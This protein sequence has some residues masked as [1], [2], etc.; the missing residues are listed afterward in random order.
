MKFASPRSTPARRCPSELTFTTRGRTASPALARNSGNSSAVSRKCARW[1]V[2]NWSSKPSAVRVSGGNITPALLTS[3]SRRS[4]SARK[5]AA[6]VRTDARS[7]R[8]TT[9]TSAR[10]PDTSSRNRASAASSLARSRAA[11]VTRA[12]CAASAR[13]VSKPIPPDAPVMRNSVPARSR[14]AST[15]SAVVVASNVTTSYL[16]HHASRAR[17]TPARAPDVLTGRCGQVAGVATALKV[18]PGPG[19]SWFKTGVSSE[20]VLNCGI[21]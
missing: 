2:P 6:N 4:R 13:A 10:A 12:P 18:L 17:R 14:P 20:Q 3:T 16:A 19:M 7:A 9:A 21:V 5:S 15:S 8:S 11:S 1:F